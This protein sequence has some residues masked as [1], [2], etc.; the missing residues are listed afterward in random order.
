MKIEEMIKPFAGDH[1]LL[2]GSH[3]AVIGIYTPEDSQLWG[4]LPGKSRFFRYCLCS[5]CQKKPNTP[6]RVEKVIMAELVSGGVTC[7]E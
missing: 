2:C 6:E 5:S 1:C 7:A 4:A 3:P